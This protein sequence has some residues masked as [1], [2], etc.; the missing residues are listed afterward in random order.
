[1]KSDQFYMAEALKLAER[2][3]YSCQPNPRVGCIVVNNGRVVGRGFHKKTGEAHAEV[4]ALN[5]ADGKA[6][7]ADIFVTLE[8]CS[9]TGK[10]PPCAD[11]LI[12]SQAARV[13]VAM[14]DPNPMVSGRGIER[15]KSSGIQ[16]FCGVCEAEAIH[17]NRGF[18]KRMKTGRPFV[19]LKLA[20]SL[21][22]RVAM[23]SGESAWITSDAARADVHRMRLDSC[24][25]LTGINT[26][27]A[28]DPKMTVRLASHQ[29]DSKYH[30]IDRQPVRVVLDSA[31]RLPVNAAINSQPGV[32]WQIISDRLKLKERVPGLYSL[33]VTDE[34]IDLH[35]LLDFLGE[36]ETNNL[37]VEA[38]GTLAA[39]F[40]AQDLVDEL[41]VYQAPD[42]MGASAQP[43]INLPQILKMSEKIKLEYQDV[44]KIGRDLKC[45]LT[46]GSKT[47]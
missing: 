33:P 1:V 44:R 47:N 42:I 14:K 32:A 19:R 7:G 9:H 10:T 2:G 41:V 26:V 11:A 27:L 38:G 18:I 30:L 12:K 4:M 15:L 16:V 13:V 46:P 40:I 8:P 23:A 37:M 31:Q 28:D 34:R 6:R 43:M 45:V 25:V 21:D 5:E 39:A 3:R 20:T 35:A 17:L 29:L 22:G 36:Q 24:A